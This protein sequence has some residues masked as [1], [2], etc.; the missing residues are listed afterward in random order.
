MLKALYY[1][2]K[3]QN[4]NVPKLKKVSCIYFKCS[5]VWAFFCN[6]KPI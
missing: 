4:S 6:Y 5:I 2:L 1:M 3:A